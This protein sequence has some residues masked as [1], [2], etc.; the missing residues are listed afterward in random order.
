MPL[1]STIRLCASPS[2]YAPLDIVSWTQGR[3]LS[4]GTGFLRPEQFTYSSD[5]DIS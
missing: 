5:T 4:S 3:S 2:R 1:A